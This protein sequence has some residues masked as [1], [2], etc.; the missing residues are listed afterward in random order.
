MKISMTRLNPLSNHLSIEKSGETEEESKK[1]TIKRAPLKIILPITIFNLQSPKDY[2][3]NKTSVLYQIITSKTRNIQ[4]K[5][6]L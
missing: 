5:A 4:K 6:G 3:H 1:N 2:S